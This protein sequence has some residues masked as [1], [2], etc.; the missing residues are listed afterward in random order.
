MM[1]TGVTPTLRLELR[2]NYQETDL[3]SYNVIA[4]IPGEDPALKDQIVLVGAH[5]DSLP[6][7]AGATDNGDGAAEAIEAMRILKAVGAHPRRTI[8]VAIWSGEEMGCVGGGAYVQQP[9][10]DPVSRDKVAVYLNNDPGTGATY[11][12]Y[13]ANNADARGIFDAWLGPLKDLGLKRNV[14]DSNFTSEDGGFERAGRPAFPTTKANTT[15]PAHCGPPPRQNNPDFLEAGSE[16]ALQQSTIVMA[17]FAYQSAM[18]DKT[19]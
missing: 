18:S 10:A 4:E 12:W 6:A 1:Q 3:N 2:T 17:V 14:M 13:M 15:R 5:L 11:G 9:L 16:G 8:R 7:A 19:M